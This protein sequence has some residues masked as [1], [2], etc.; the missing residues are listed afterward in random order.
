M[1][2]ARSGTACGDWKQ[3]P[4]KKRPARKPAVGTVPIEY[5]HGYDSCPECDGKLARKPAKFARWSRNGALLLFDGRV[6][7]LSYHEDSNGHA[8]PDSVVRAFNDAGVV[9]PKARRP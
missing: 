8:D 9:L 4:Q 1:T 7:L 6:K 5:P 3:R 2:N